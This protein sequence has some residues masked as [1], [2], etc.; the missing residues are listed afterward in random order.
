[1][2]AHDLI[3]KGISPIQ[4]SLKYQVLCEDTAMIGVVKQKEKATSEVKEY[5]QTFEKYAK[6]SQPVPQPY[7]NQN[8]PHA[9]MMRG[10]GG[11]RGAR[12]GMAAYAPA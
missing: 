5:E 9:P 12:L 8:V 7:Y 6:K 10:R 11:G 2:A 1:M 3:L 4:N